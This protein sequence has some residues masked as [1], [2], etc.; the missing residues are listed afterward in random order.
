MG[1]GDWGTVIAW[2]I[3][4]VDR[5]S[6]I[7]KRRSRLNEIKKQDNMV[8]GNNDIALD[9]ELRKIRKKSNDRKNV[10]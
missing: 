9:N 3:K 2:V 5:V 10:S 4:I 6:Y 8:D 1:L 7:I